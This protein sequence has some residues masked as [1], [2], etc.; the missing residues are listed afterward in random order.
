MNRITII[1]MCWKRPAVFRAFLL[2]HSRLIPAPH[3]VC[4]GSPNDECESIARE[5]NVQY[6]S[7]A[8]DPTGRKGNDAAEAAKGTGDYYLFTGSDDLMSQGLYYYYL[9]FDGDHIGLEDLYF[10]NIPDK[11]L[12]YWAGYQRT[13]AHFGEP[14]GACKMVSKELMEFVKWRPYNDKSRYPEEH[15]THKAFIGPKGNRSGANLEIKKMQEMGGACVD[16]KSKDS[17][18]KFKLFP[19]SKYVLK[20]ELEE[21]GPDIYEIIKAL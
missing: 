17:I 16:L 4:A 2:N 1:T 9:K 18:T 8:N 7:V 19:N 14:I 15:D 11:R 10:Y 6:I 12:I 20:S 21:R 3:I 5:Y 13:S